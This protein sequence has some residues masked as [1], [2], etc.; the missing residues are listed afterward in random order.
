MLD[1]LAGNGHQSEVIELKHFRRRF[2][3][4]ES[5]LQCLGDL[6]PVLAVLHVDE[7]ANDNASQVA[8]PQ[9]PGNLLGCLDVGLGNGVFQLVRPAHVLAG[10]HVDGHQSLGLVDNDVAPRFQ[11]NL[12]SQGFVQFR[13]NPELFE[14]G[15]LSGVK[16]D[17]IDQ[18][19]LESV[20]QLHHG[21][22][23]QLVI[24]ANGREFLGELVPEN[25]LHQTEFTMDDGRGGLFLGLTLDLCPEGAKKPDVR[26]EFVLSLVLPGG[27]N[28][29][30]AG[31]V[32]SVVQDDFLESL[33]LLAGTDLAGDSDVV[34]RRHVDQ[35]A[36]RKSDMGGNA[37]PLG[38]Q[39]LLRNLDQNLLALLEQVGDQGHGGGRLTPLAFLAL[40]GPLAVW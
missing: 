22:V 1:P 33:A 9:L 29:E 30:P 4:S 38:S 11:P 13:L 7:I 40:S 31:Q 5:F 15:C 19:G 23:H 32:A 6:E 36:P 28:N 20:D 18:A 26:F 35:V 8:Q 27:T 3:P 34:D 37:R 12:G 14:Y 24:H 17:P 21:G 39:R 10:V 16:L 25:P 2:F